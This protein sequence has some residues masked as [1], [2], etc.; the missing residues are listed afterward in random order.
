MRLHSE[1]A[2]VVGS[3]DFA[4]NFAAD[5]ARSPQRSRFGSVAASVLLVATA[6]FVGIGF[7][8]NHDAKEEN[9][10]GGFVLLAQDSF[11]A[12]KDHI[13]TFPKEQASTTQALIWDYAAEDGDEVQVEVDGVPITPPFVITHKPLVV[14]APSSGALV[15]RGIKDGGGGGVT[16]AIRFSDIGTSITNG[17]AIGG[18]NTYTLQV[19]KS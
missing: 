19:K 15:V 12:P 3:D 9:L 18:M 4:E 6:V 17:V 1:R 5:S 14:M 13:L 2:E 8:A 11:R 10:P 16:Y 7:L